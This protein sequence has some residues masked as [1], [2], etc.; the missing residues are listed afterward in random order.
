LSDLGFSLTLGELYRFRRY[1]NPKLARLIERI[2]G[3]V[4]YIIREYISEPL[5]S[6]Q[7]TVSMY[8]RGSQYSNSEDR[9]LAA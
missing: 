7:E 6:S 4:E 8:T 5:E 9:E 2:P 1:D 3:Q